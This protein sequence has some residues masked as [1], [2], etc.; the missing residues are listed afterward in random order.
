MNMARAFIIHQGDGQDRVKETKVGE[1]SCASY[2]VRNNTMHL[3]EMYFFIQLE[4]RLKMSVSDSSTLGLVQRIPFAITSFSE[5]LCNLSMRFNTN[6]K[7]GE[8]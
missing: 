6:I 1:H 8:R 3:D 2:C 7:A 5:S 4:K